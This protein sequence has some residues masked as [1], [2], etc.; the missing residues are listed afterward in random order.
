[1]HWLNA[2]RPACSLECVYCGAS[3][4][5]TLVRIA[6]AFADLM[7]ADCPHLA[8]TALA[9]KDAALR[10]ETNMPGRPSPI[11]FLAEP[12]REPEMADGEDAREEA[13][14]P[15]QPGDSEAEAPVFV[16]AKCGAERGSLARV[17]A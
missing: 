8:A 16:A 11:E 3:G 6:A 7:A 1:M 5:F 12:M 4:R 2:F 15:E 13:S 14:K 9:F 17:G 10:L